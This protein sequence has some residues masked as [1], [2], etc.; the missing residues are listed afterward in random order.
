MSL[1]KH[2][3]EHGNPGTSITQEEEAERVASAAAG[4]SAAGLKRQ[5]LQEDMHDHVAKSSSTPGR[6]SRTLVN[7]WLDSLLAVVFVV[8]CISAVVVQ[9][10]FPPGVAADGWTLW[11]MS[12][13][14]WCSIQFS[15]MT[16]L[17]LGVLVHVMLHWTW[18]CSVLVKRVLRRR[19]LPD[20]GTRTVYGVGLLICLLLLGA[21]TVGMAQWMIVRPR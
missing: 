12:Y 17:A 7:F 8:L 3:S 5:L 11:S 16:T 9:F 2:H 13:G 10:V 15:L 4:N 1:S 19:D 14:Q 6:I 21:V 20:N 18:V